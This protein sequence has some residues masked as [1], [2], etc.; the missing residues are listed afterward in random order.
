MGSIFRARRVVI[1]A[2]IV[3]LV[4]GGL[5]VAPIA[6]V[7]NQARAVSSVEPRASKKCVGAA[8]T[9]TPGC[10]L[11]GN[12]L[13]QSIGLAA[14]DKPNVYADSCWNFAPTFEH[15]I[16]C[17]Y[18]A[19]NPKVKI[20]VIGNSH[21]GHWVPAL[22]PLLASNKSWGVD[23]YILSSCYT[24]NAKV[25]VNEIRANSTT[26]EH[27]RKA[28][29]WSVNSVIKGKYDL[30][31]ISNRT[32]TSPLTGVAPSKQA[33]TAKALYSNVL[34]NLVNG[35]I[36]TLVIR[37]T[38][39]LHTRT[40]QCI[41]E[42]PHNWKVCDTPQSTALE[43]DPLAQ[44]AN[45]HRSPIITLAS[46]TSA[47][48]SDGKCHAVIG[49]L[50]ARF[51]QSHMTHTFSQ[52]FAPKMRTWV[53]A[54]LSSGPRLTVR[55][56]NAGSTKARKSK[57]LKVRVSNT[58]RAKGRITAIKVRGKNFKIQKSGTCKKNRSLSAKSSCRIT[59]RF[60]PTSRG[61]KTGNATVTYELGRRSVAASAVLIGRGR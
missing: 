59:I 41:K 1:P 39:Q 38:P 36:R 46:P 61:R 51:D 44:A 3:A 24:V 20:A 52:S 35:G 57:T 29:I 33:S 6:T 48:C 15:R 10:S 13:H 56:V 5:T 53:N 16:V 14:Q 26:P 22:M 7:T 2:A 43:V 4:A 11:L 8:A 32:A 54:A 58:G 18:G 19:K 34:S 27:C 55:N 12:K 37:D 31:V 23:T 21:A 45:D 30:V 28:S 42:N 9:W 40:P 25:S 47:M 49:G 50:I 17:K 60:L